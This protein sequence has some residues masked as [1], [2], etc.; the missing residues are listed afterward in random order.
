MGT[1]GSK[2]Q[3]P[4][5]TATVSRAGCVDDN[6]QGVAPNFAGSQRIVDVGN[7]LL[8]ER[9]N[10]GRVLIVFGMA[11]IGKVLWFDE[12]IGWQ[13]SGLAVGLELR[14][15]LEVAA[16]QEQLQQCVCLCNVVEIDLP[17]SVIGFFETIVDCRYVKKVRRIIVLVAVGGSGV[18]EPVVADSELPWGL[19][20]LIAYF[21]PDV[22]SLFFTMNFF[23]RDAR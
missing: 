22:Y 1:P 8:A 11:E 5:T 15:G 14:V 23:L 4:A 18:G 19:Q 16:E 13:Q 20:Q 2:S 21:A 7:Q 17:V 9:D 6:K 12:R 3:R 10:R